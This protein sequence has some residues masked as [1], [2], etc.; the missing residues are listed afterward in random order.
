MSNSN[1]YRSRKNRN[2]R[3]KRTKKIPKKSASTNNSSDFRS[4]L[5]L[6]NPQNQVYEGS[7]FDYKSVKKT[8]YKGNGEDLFF[9][10][11]YLSEKYSSFFIPMGDFEDGVIMW[12]I[13]TSWKCDSFMDKKFKLNLPKPKELFIQ[14]IKR[15]F[16]DKERKIRFIL[17]PLYL[18][19]SDCR[20]EK[21]HFNI[22]IV[23]VKY[24]TYERFEPYG[25][26]V[27]MY[28]HRPL[29]SKIKKI[30]KEAGVK[31]KVIELNEYLPKISFQEIE[32]RELE[33]SIASLRETDPG[34]FC[35]SWAV[36]YV[37]LVFK[38]KHLTRKE[39]I[40]KTIKLIKDK[41]NFRNFIRNYSAHLVRSR[42]ELLKNISEECAKSIDGNQY[43]QC[44]KEYITN[45]I[46]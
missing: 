23:D 40:K 2:S 8:S 12:N 34:G 30:F 24:K 9:S 11:R 29:N 25:Y 17:L 39:L 46:K 14:D 16:N 4:M 20:V 7:I 37:E 18:G 19:S 26:S 10:F 27:N 35:G 43:F 44:T 32:E 13:L 1:R 36:W 38:N 41:S 45:Y 22:A 31:L 6:N 33:K 3:I 21:G 42:K 5:S 15:I 28:I